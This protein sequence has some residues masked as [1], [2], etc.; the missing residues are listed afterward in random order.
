MVIE[1][2]G[3]KNDAGYWVKGDGGQKHGFALLEELMSE[4]VV[5]LPLLLDYSAGKHGDTPCMGTRQ[6]IERQRTV[7]GGKKMEKLKLGD[8]SYISYQEVR[9]LVVNFAQGLHSLDIKSGDR[10]AMLAE[11]RSEWFISAMGCLRQNVAVVTLYTNLPDDSIAIS[12]QETEVKT[13]ISSYDL[14]PRL[15][16]VLPQCP[17]V[18]E[19]IV[20]EDQLEGTGSIPEDGIKLIPFKEVLSLGKSCENV[21]EALPKPEDLAIIMYTSGSTNQPKGVQLT[22]TNVMSAIKAYIIQA[23]LTV[24]DRYLA[25]LP[26]AHVMELATE[27]ALIA[28]NV[29]IAYSSPMTLTSNSPKIMKGTLGDAKIAHPTCMSA[30]PLILERV[31]KGVSAAVEN[32]GYLKAMLFTKALKYKQRHERPS[33]SSRVLDAII[34]NKVK[35]ELGGQLRMMVVGGAP[36]SPEIHN[37]FRAIFGCTIQVGY[38]ATETSASITSMDSDDPRTGHCGPPNLDVLVKLRDWVEGGYLSTDTPQP[39]GEIIVG[40][41]MISKGYYKLPKETDEAFVEEDGVR[42]FLTGDIGEFDETGVL[43][44]IDRKKD[45]VKLENGEYVSLGNIESRLKTHTLI[46][47]LCV[48]ANPG[49]KCVVAVMVPVAEQLKKIGVTCGFHEDTSLKE[50]CNDEKVKTCVLEELKSH[51]KKQGLGRWDFPA[52]IHLTPEPW[53]PESGLVTAALKIRRK[54]IKDHFRDAIMSMYD[55]VS[56]SE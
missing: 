28:M 18:K 5:T 19:V 12:L 54:N 17:D 31:I 53:T 26:L 8:Y 50:L 55:K 49:A 6:V 16:K 41:P 22:H 39:R 32:Q 14:L 7:E 24:G 9:N 30:V 44:V 23:D 13:V 10:V 36:L 42:W 2:G 27:L 25:Y 34:F 40:G 21:A 38:G 56:K 48:I 35:D 20:I 3:K 33:F 52:A 1:G 11:T 46:E 15:M 43:R 47:S 45:L 37:K 29:T 51:G 4:N